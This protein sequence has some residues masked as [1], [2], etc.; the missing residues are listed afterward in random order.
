MMIMKKTILLP[1]V[2]FAVLICG[3]QHSGSDDAKIDELAKKVET[4]LSNQATINAK[5]DM[6]PSM[7]SID[8]ETFYYYTNTLNKLDVLK[9]GIVLIHAQ[10]NVLDAKVDFANAVGGSIY[11]N[12]DIIQRVQIDMM[13]SA[14][15]R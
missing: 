1:P 12:V 11:T 13:R 3:C 14:P 8:S 10:N 9:A 15:L 5:L 2:L 7:R 6:L 4:V